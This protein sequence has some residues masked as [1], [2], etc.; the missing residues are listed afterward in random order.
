MMK[1]YRWR[2][3]GVLLLTACLTVARADDF[4][5][6][7]TAYRA[8]DYA[9]ARQVFQ[10]LAQAGDAP[11]QFAL[12]LLYDNGDGVPQ[13]D[14]TAAGW[15]EKSANQGYAKAQYNLGVMHL[16]GR[17]VPRND[18]RARRWFEQAAAQG[19]SDA[20]ARIIQFAEG[21]DVEAQY[22]LALMY[23]RGGA[24]PR[25]QA[26]SYRWM[27]RA[28]ARGH[29]NAMFGMGLLAETGQGTDRSYAAAVNWYVPASHQG[30]VQATYNLARLVRLGQGQP[31]DLARAAQLYEKAASAG[32]VPAQLSLG[33]LFD[34]GEGW[35]RNPV[36]AV[37]WYKLA[38][39]NGSADAQIN[40][41]Y[42]YATGGGGVSRDP[43][44]A[45]ARTYAGERLGHPLGTVNLALMGRGL[46]A[47][48]VSLAQ[49]RGR[50]YLN[51]ARSL[52]SA[53][54]TRDEPSTPT[55]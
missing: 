13:N 41:G 46:E 9:A 39:N 26:L 14:V 12:G 4:A 6:G 38:A 7:V 36:S 8:Q 27:Q 48:E 47:S 20:V 32:F 23:L 25:D 17:G 1:F 31:R 30:Q 3:S 49:A 53:N 2:I 52:P 5:S 28:A 55:P 33:M 16:T 37:V 45:Y 10:R 21:G 18:A 54:L 44:E 11:A 34:F 29:L 35:P 19:N 51:R 42:L 40:L 15:Y 24:V 22:R 50:G 43:I